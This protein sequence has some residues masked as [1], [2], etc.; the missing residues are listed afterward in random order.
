MTKLYYKRHFN[1]S[2]IEKFETWGTCGFYFESNQKGEI[3]RQIEVYEN[4]RRL[5][6]SE[7]ILED[8]FGFLSDQK[9]DLL[10]FEKFIINKKDFEYQWEQ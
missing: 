9:I 5:K 3:L 8:E 1:E 6:Y 4:G 7:E 10:E 2:R